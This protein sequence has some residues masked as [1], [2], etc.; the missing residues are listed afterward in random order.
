M[1]SAGIAQRRPVESVSGECVSE[2]MLLCRPAMI[3][4]I[5]R[6]AKNTKSPLPSPSPDLIREL[7]CD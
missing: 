2:T 1:P 3:E 5:L 4:Y 7:L 6:F